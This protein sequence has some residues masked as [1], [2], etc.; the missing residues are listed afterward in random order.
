MSNIL[1]VNG[2]LP[3]AINAFS[4][5][6]DLALRL[7]TRRLELK[8]TRKKLAEK[9]GVSPGSIKRFENNYEISLKHLLALS[10]ILDAT[11]GFSLLFTKKQYES[12][13]EVLKS[14][15]EQKRQRGRRNV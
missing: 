6:K 7:K 15:T 9:S 14:Q 10:I 8:F 2:F 1:A 4:I 11:E 13:D 5:A 3:E 12:I